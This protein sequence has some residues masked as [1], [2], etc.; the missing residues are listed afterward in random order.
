MAKQKKIK[1]DTGIKSKSSGSQLEPEDRRCVNQR[2]KEARYLSARNPSGWSYQK[3][4]RKA[5]TV[6]KNGRPLCK[7]CSNA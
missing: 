4:G 7:K 5:I 6:D 1:K 3:C 2:Q